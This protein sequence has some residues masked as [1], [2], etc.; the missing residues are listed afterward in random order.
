MGTEAR[1]KDSDR[2]NEGPC[3]TSTSIRLPASSFANPI[4]FSIFNEERS[5]KMPCAEIHVIFS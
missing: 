2:T 4:L 1:E 5:F 3:A